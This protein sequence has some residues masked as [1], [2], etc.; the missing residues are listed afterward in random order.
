MEQLKEFQTTLTKMLEGNMSLVDEINGMQLV[1]RHATGGSRPL[2]TLFFL[3]F[4][5]RRSK[6]Q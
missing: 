3:S 4:S 1:R 5:A 6:R 2:T